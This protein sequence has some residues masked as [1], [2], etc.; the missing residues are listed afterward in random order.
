MNV[1]HI[2]WSVRRVDMDHDYIG[3]ILELAERCDT[4][5]TGF[6]VERGADYFALTRFFGDHRCWAVFDPKR[7]LVGSLG[8]TT[9]RRYVGGRPVAVD[10]LHDL[11]IDRDF[12]HALVCLRLLSRVAAAELESGRP[13]IATILNDDPADTALVHLAERYFGT[14]RLLTR[15]EHVLASSASSVPDYSVSAITLAT[16]ERAYALWARGTDGAP[17]V[18]T[19]RRAQGVLLGA[20]DA[21]GRLVAVC[22]V[23]DQHGQRVVRSPDGAPLDVL[24]LAFFAAE[25][26]HA[27]GH[28]AFRFHAVNCQPDTTIA[29]GRELGWAPAAL[30]STTWGFGAAAAALPR[31][32]AHE[33][34]LV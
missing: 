20:R 2:G 31:L 5:N 11:L 17:D 34:T 32:T 4:H 30:S 27:R 12:R 25:P 19:C 18:A 24:Y 28:A 10:Y 7:R 3:A 6:W 29:Y 33:L 21:A 14:A 16:W 1:A 15:S 22:K 23:V 9:Q 13:R 8:V 26:K